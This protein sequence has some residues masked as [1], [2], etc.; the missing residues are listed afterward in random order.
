M[1]A[2]ELPKPLAPIED[3]LGRLDGD[4]IDAYE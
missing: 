2:Y 4:N 3:A 1:N